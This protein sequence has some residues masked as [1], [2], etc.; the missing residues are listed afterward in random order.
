MRLRPASAGRNRWWD[1]DCF[2]TV[3]M[4]QDGRLW[5]HK[6]VRWNGEDL[7]ITDDSPARAGRVGQGS[8][9]SIRHRCWIA[10]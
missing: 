3:R 6:V 5:A 2:A 4:T 9:S 10:L 1:A 7:E 8:S